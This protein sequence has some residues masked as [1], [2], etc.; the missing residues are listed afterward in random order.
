VIV[1]TVAGEFEGRLSKKLINK[2]ISLA[3]AED[4]EEIGRDQ[5][6]SME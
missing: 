4:A 1:E 2:I 5:E 6:L 3:F